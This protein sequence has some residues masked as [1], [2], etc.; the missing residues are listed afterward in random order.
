MKHIHGTSN[1][2]ADACR[3]SVKEQ[4]FLRC[5]TTCRVCQHLSARLRSKCGLGVCG[6]DL[7]TKGEPRLCDRL[8]VTRRLAMG[9][10]AGRAFVTDVD[11]GLR[12]RVTL[13]RRALL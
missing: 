8:F 11:D 9:T 12:A 2:S 13:V 10:T 6:W 3:G 5:W 1:K 7:H 4:L